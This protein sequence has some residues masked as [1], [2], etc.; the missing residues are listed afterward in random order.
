VK[1]IEREGE[2]RERVK[3]KEIGG[4]GEREGEIGVS[5]KSRKNWGKRERD[6]IYRNI[7][8]DI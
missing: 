1:E 4:E 7:Y 8:I 2:M 3:D 5:D 6:Y